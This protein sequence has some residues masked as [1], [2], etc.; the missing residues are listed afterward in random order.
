MI[1]DISIKSIKPLT[2]NAMWH[3]FFS[4]PW[5]FIILLQKY[6]DGAFIGFIGFDNFLLKIKKKYEKL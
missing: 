3:L 6:H 1:F 4:S 5:G 2:Q